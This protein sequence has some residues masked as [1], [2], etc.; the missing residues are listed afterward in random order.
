MQN[1]Y[2]KLSLVKLQSNISFYKLNIFVIKFKIIMIWEVVLRTELYA[3]DVEALGSIPGSAWP[4]S[5]GAN[6]SKQSQVQI[7]PGIAPEHQQCGP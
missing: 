4:L 6:N 7:I 3:L 1:L 5:T 2:A